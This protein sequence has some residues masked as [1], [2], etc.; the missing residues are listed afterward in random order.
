MKKITIILLLLTSGISTIFAQKR[1]ESNEKIEA[2]RIAFFTQKLDLTESESKV[3]WPIYNAYQKDLRTLRS[4]QRKL[5]K[6]NYEELSDK[7]LEV[8]I[9]NRFESKQKQLDL[10]R[11]YYSKFKKVL[12]MKK[13]ARLPRVERAFKSALLEKMRKNEK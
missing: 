11:R 3:F 4:K 10:E 1:G 12:P 9:E 6:V 8:M 2:F 7:E 13:V 5:Y